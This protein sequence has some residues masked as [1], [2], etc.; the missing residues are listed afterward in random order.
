MGYIEEFIAHYTREYDF[1]QRAAALVAGLLEADL[2]AA[3]IRGIVTSR[4]KATSRLEDK[5]RQRDRVKAYTSADE[6]YDDT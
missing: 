6:I 3:G 1:Y 2:R 5:C 4:A